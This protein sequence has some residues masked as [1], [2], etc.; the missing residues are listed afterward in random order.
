MCK[1][2]EAPGLP[3][4]KLSERGAWYARG[5]GGAEGAFKAVIRNSGFIL[6]SLEPSKGV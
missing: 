4:L 1:G 5:W 3:Q 2:P 6:G